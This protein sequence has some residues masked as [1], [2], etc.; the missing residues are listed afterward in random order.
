MTRWVFDLYTDPEIEAWIE[1]A[2]KEA[3]DSWSRN[4]QRHWNNYTALAEALE[5]VNKERLLFKA[6]FLENRMEYDKCQ[7][8]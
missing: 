1:C 6:W 3:H 8:L 7:G 2:F 4:K 5:Q